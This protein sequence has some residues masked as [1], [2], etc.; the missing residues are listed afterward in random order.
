MIATLA[1]G[2]RNA[3]EPR[4]INRCSMGLFAWTAA[5]A[6]VVG[7]AGCSSSQQSDTSTPFVGAWGDRLD[8]VGL[9]AIM[10][11][12]EDVRVGD[13]YV[14]NV[15]STDRMTAAQQRDASRRMVATGRWA[16]LPVLDEL[17]SEYSQRRAWPITP[18]AFAQLSQDPGV[19]QIWQ[20]A[21]A[22][23]GSSLFTPDESP[24][25]LRI[26]GLDGF[27]AVSFSTEEMDLVIPT[28]IAS[29]VS[30]ELRPDT[31][32]VTMRVGSAES[33]SLSKS[34]SISLLTE[35]VAAD[36]G[37]MQFRVRAPYRENLEFM[38]NALGRVWLH[39]ITEVVY[40]RSADIAVRP[41]KVS[42]ADDDVTAEE[43]LTVAK[44]AAATT[45][46]RSQTPAT[47]PA[48]GD[49]STAS[50]EPASAP[51][52]TGLKTLA[53]TRLDP[54]YGAFVRAQAINDVLVASN[55]NDSPGSLLRFLSV[56]DNS[57][58]VRRI[59]PRGLAIGVRGLSMEVDAA[60]GDIL[61]SGPL[62][63]TSDRLLQSMQ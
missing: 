53:A 6:V 52:R 12:S 38:A 58:S 37:R 60:T 43:L 50:Q 15:D 16:A 59:W 11:P 51:D 26:V 40:I 13:I 63:L 39:L 49:A 30:G 21:L 8:A 31:V 32:S 47:E 1:S 42:P 35:R 54:I 3:K 29:L 61:R 41:I 17:Q 33:Y 22:S 5:A 24:A 18:N 45:P 20:E 48:A 46:S 34:E 10:P 23:D 19:Q 9:V 28:E 14:F 27:S 56:T 4:M 55:A 62:G 36:D 57:V 2:I 25:R 44:A 7:L